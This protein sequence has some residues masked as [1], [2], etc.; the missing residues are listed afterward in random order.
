MEKFQGA[1]GVRKHIPAIEFYYLSRWYGNPGVNVELERY[2]ALQEVENRLNKGF[3]KV[4]E[5][6]IWRSLGPGNIAGRVRAIA[7]R[8]DDPNVVF[9]GGASGGIFKST[10]GGQNDWRPVMDFTDAIPVGAIAIDPVNPDI[11]YA[12]TGEPTADLYKVNSGPSFSGVGVF[13]STDAGESWTRLPWPQATSAIHRILIDPRNPNVILVASRANMYRSEDGGQ[14]WT[15]A[16]GG[17]I[18][19]IEFKPGNPDIVY[20]A[21]GK[22]DGA[23]V[24]GVYRSTDGGKPFTWTKL[25]N[26]FPSN[27]SLGRIELAVSAAN[28]DLL[29]AA[30][31]RKGFYIGNND[32]L[33]MMMSTDGGENWV[34]QNS[35]LPS[36]MTSGQGFYDLCLSI[37]P[38]SADTVHVGGLELWRSVNGGSSWTQI[39]SN[40]SPVHVDQHVLEYSPDN[41]YLFLGNDGGVYRS[42]NKGTTW[43]PLERTLETIQ[44]YTLAW[45][46]NNADR[47]YGG[48]QDH[49]VFQ[50]SNIDN[51]EWRIRRGGDGGYVLVDPSNPNILY[52]RLMI[53]GSGNPVPA[54]SINGGQSWTRLENGFSGDRFN[55]LTPMMLAPNDR[56]RMYTATQ[57]VYSAKPVDSGTPTFRAI[58]PDL[59]AR[60]SISSVI[61]TIDVSQSSPTTMYVG[62]GDGT[63]QYSSNITAA[64]VEWTNITNGLPNRWVSRIKID[65]RNPAIA[66]VVFSG[67][68]TPHVYK[69]T[70]FGQNWTDISGNLPNVPVNGI[71]IS[72]DDPDN[73]LFI[74][75]DIGVWYTRDGGQNWSRFGVGLPNVVVYDVDID[76]QNRLIAATFGRGMWIASAVINSVPAT[77]PTAFALAQNYPNPF[78]SAQGTTIRFTL[79]EASDV[80]LTLHD[81]TGRTLRT[82]HQ[83]RLSGGSHSVSVN[84]SE[85]RNGVYFYT[86]S[87]GRQRSMKK[88]VVLN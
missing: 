59:T 23:L 74:G 44:F 10:N 7:F 79:P 50:S 45:D 76:N 19:D 78:A 64:D 63:V 9:A 25:S 66:Y 57:F 8:P 12:G 62:C 34:R 40:G 51:K 77:A 20:L 1:K 86:I 28:P 35:N 56:T 67:I 39:S 27:D 73:T 70:N 48:V 61:S 14:N 68:N 24:N 88:M 33:A 82:L 15:R 60:N 38:T 41:K 17:V 6:N 49:G 42:L 43:T 29:M 2:K 37:A 32:F 21:I 52:S 80:M 26:N 11:M 83:G 69:T 16:Q 22:D 18:T 65:R 58:S 75:S 5:S 30:V 87:D 53:E 47:F 81:A 85:L 36:T 4:T 55:W 84:T 46:P 13:K 71:V 3:D 31:V 72:R 54:R